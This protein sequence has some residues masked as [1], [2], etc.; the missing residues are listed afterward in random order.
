MILILIFTETLKATDE[1]K[2]E[3]ILVSGES[4]QDLRK[5]FGKNDLLTVNMF[6]IF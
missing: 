6:G 3:E 5:S 2:R 1:S 4:V